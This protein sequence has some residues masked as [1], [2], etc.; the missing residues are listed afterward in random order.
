MYTLGHVGLTLMINHS[1]EKKFGYKL[2]IME[3]FLLAFA[4][5]VPDILDKSIGIIFFGTGRWIGHTLLF[6]ITFSLIIVLINFHKLCAYLERFDIF[7]RIS[8]GLDPSRIRYLF[9]G[10]VIA[11]LIGDILTLGPVVFLWP[12]LGPFPQLDSS[13]GFLYGFSNPI[14]S[15][16]EILG[17]I[18]L[19]YLS[20]VNGW[21]KTG[22]FVILLLTVLYMGSYALAY[23]LLVGI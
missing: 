16:G 23:Y 3:Y 4:S 6:L 14:I 9:I 7:S 8:E 15:L 5:M 2:S 18:S 1:T 19:L 22:V 21:K 13:A 20:H 12:L 11:H 10:G 17:F